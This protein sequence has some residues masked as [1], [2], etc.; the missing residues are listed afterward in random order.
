VASDPKAVPVVPV[1]EQTV[2]LGVHGV[3][4]SGGGDGAAARDDGAELVV[5]GHLVVDADGAWRHARRPIGIEGFGG[6]PGPQ[7][8]GAVAGVSGGDAEGEGVEVGTRGGEGT[9]DADGAG[10]E[11]HGDTGA[12]VAEEGASGDGRFHKVVSPQ[13]EGR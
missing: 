1:G 13:R 10:A 4:E 3:A 12:A 6:Q 5:A 9:A 7:D 2:D 11:Q 8:D